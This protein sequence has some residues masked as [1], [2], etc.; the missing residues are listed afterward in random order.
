MFTGIA[1]DKPLRDYLSGSYKIIRHFN[2]P[3]H[4]EF[5]RNDIAS[6][7][8]AADAHPTSVIMTTEKDSQ[9]I[10]DFGRV[11]E[12]M[13]KRMFHAPIKAEF[14]SDRDREIFFTLL[15]SFLK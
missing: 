2:F 14:T 9:R 12:W 6:I 13:K 10:L 8:N 5:T 1:N 4:H 11:P 3:D 7:K 15:K